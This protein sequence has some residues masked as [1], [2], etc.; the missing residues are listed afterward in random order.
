[1]A[2]SKNTR[3]TQ[4]RGE[5]DEEFRQFRDEHDMSTSEALR[6]LVRNGLEDDNRSSSMFGRPEEVG[7]LAQL[8]AL[9]G[10]VAAL[11]SAAVQWAITV[12]LFVATPAAAAALGTLHNFLWAV[13]AGLVAFS[14]AMAVAMYLGGDSE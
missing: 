9:F 8:L 10:I 3:A 11:L 5:M 2:E 6:T 7:H 12:G 13:A 1:M 14:V 4:L